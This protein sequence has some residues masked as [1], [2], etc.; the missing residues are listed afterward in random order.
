MRNPK[1]LVLSG[2]ARA[3]S[4]NSQLAALAAKKLAILDAKVTRISL[5][6]YPLPIYDGDLEEAD[7][8][9]ENAEKLKNCLPNMTAF[10]SLARSITRESRRF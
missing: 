4:Y 2:S 8:V 1:I 9:P 6:D 5:K 7:G 3:G 10:L